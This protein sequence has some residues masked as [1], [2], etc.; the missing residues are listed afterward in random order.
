MREK[1]IIGVVYVVLTAIVTTI[2]VIIVKN[3]MNNFKEE[4]RIEIRKEAQSWS[5]SIEVS[6]NRVKMIDSL[7]YEEITAIKEDIVSLWNI[8]R[9]T[10]T[11]VQEAEKKAEQELEERKTIGKTLLDW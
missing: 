6:R 5:D 9:M 10:W 8:R 7:S 2:S 11:E 4:L 1:I 3:A